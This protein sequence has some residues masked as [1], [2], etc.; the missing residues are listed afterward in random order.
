[1]FT[2]NSIVSV[3]LSVFLSFLPA[4]ARLIHEAPLH[5]GGEP[6]STSPPQPRPLDLIED[7]V[8]PLEQDLLGLIPVS[9]LLG[10]L[11]PDPRENQQNCDLCNNWNSQRK[12]LYSHRDGNHE[13]S[14]KRQRVTSSRDD[15]TDL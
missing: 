3:C 14:T 5:A 2:G 10:P 4:I 13:N 11:Q 12:I 6:S 1:M 8:H 7:P 9:T 15:H